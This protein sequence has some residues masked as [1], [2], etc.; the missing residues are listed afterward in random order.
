MSTVLLFI[1]WARRKVCSR[2]S[3]PAKSSQLLTTTSSMYMVC[4]QIHYLCSQPQWQHLEISRGLQAA[5]VRGTASIKSAH[6]VRKISSVILSVILTAPAKLNELFRCSSL[7]LHY[8][9]FSS[10]HYWTCKLSIYWNLLPQFVTTC[11]VSCRG[12]QR[13]RLRRALAI[14]LDQKAFRSFSLTATTQ[15]SHRGISSHAR[16]RC[17]CYKISMTRS[18]V[19]WLFWYCPKAFWLFFSLI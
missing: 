17:G 9:Y 19:S 2:G 13:K 10:I 11:L 6:V 14:P 3:M 4:P 5:I 1:C 8:V 15:I 18:F 7:C 12:C 16:T